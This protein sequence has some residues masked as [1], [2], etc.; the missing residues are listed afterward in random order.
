MPVPTA[1]APPPTEIPTMT[2][3]V[4]TVDDVVLEFVLAGVVEIEQF[5]PDHPVTHAH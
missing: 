2:P 5:V 4:Q 3:V 1:A